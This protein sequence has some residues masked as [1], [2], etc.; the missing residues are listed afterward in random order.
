MTVSTM[1]NAMNFRWWL[2]ALSFCVLTFPLT[3]S[4]QDEAGTPF[5][6]T[7]DHQSLED[8]TVTLRHRDSME[9]ERV[10]IDQLRS[11]VHQKVD[12]KHWLRELETAE[13]PS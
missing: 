10:A 13:S 8:G 6:V 1:G 2:V 5:C 11:I 12:M 3:A 7:V 9:Q 4:A